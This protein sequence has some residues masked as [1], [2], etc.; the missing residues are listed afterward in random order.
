MVRDRPSGRAELYELYQG[1]LYLVTN[2][3]EYFAGVAEAN[4]DS[5]DVLYHFLSWAVGRCQ[6]VDP[7][8]PK[9]FLQL[10]SHL[11][12]A[13]SLH[14]IAVKLPDVLFSLMGRRARI[15]FHVCAGR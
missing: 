7:T 5:A 10:G 9:Y 15:F 6:A 4:M 14:S 2:T 8:E 11:W 12:W 13:R 3:S 1:N